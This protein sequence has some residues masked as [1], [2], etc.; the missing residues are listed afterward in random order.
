MA[1]FG[2]RLSRELTVRYIAVLV[3]LGVLAIGSFLVLARFLGDAEA[4]TTLV[5]VAGRQRLLVERAA[6]AA[7]RLSVPSVN[8][9]E[10]TRA[11]RLLEESLDTLESSQIGLAAGLP[12]LGRAQP[13]SA[14]IRLLLTGPD[15]V[16][17]R[18]ADFVARGRSVAGRAEGGVLPGDDPDVN[19]MVDAAE[20]SLLASLDVLAKGYQTE[21]RAGLVRLTV[22]HG[23][24]LVVMLL[25]LLLSAALVFRPLV[26]RLKQ[27]INQRCRAEKD[28]RD[29]EER[30]WRI[31]EESPVGVSVS[32]RTDGR[33]VF[34][35]TRFCEI[36]ET[37]AEDVIGRSAREHYV[38]DEQ[39][40]TVVKALKTSGRIDDVPV[41][42]RRKDGT[43]FWSL[44]TIRPTHFEGEPV[45]LA[46]VY[47]I[48]SLKAAEEQLKLAGKVVETANEAVVITNSRNEI[49]FVNPAF[50]NITEYSPEEV[51]GKNPAMLQSGRHD[52]D[53]Y[54]EMWRDLREQGRWR[55]E[56]WNR[57]KS[58]EF[59]A[60]WLSIVAIRDAS[61]AVTHH[62]AV[63]SDI[64]HRKEDEER[65][66]RQA[67]YDVLTG[68]PNRALF[69]DRLSQAVRQS[70]RDAKHFA[71]MF[72][73]LDGFK[74]VNDTLGHAAGDILLQQ[75]AQR[76]T[77]CMRASDTVARLAGDEFTIIMQGI[78]GREDTAM[79]AAKI[80]ETL[81]QPFDLDGRIAHVRGSIGIAIF[82]EDAGDGPSMLE[83]ADAAMYAVKKRGKNNF[84]F[85]G[86][87]V[88]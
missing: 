23:S 15:G 62:I 20:G 61:G 30:L 25:M 79:V 84:A 48:S 52:A 39:R 11:T 57:R 3:V 26:G 80:L 43:P 8:S 55:G 74:Q 69:V 40:R 58:G 64:T 87:P 75:A 5:N 19:A 22:L 67:N 68:L 4:G 53:F 32:R 76:L 35:N 37:P 81:G 49:Q 9:G 45:N 13:P 28:L 71:L 38:D 86:E 46:W 10:R 77:D 2:E 31:L 54:R 17:P 72:I 1:D 63:F 83:L 7:S 60:E 14:A 50:T 36:V 82:P 18:L 42:F 85:A 29:S 78:H 27:D 21:G 44:L 24:A 51:L 65:V 41:E 34:A 59:F 66:W 73:D 33:V 6:L 47:D 70:R 88:A 12:E 16:G 56:I